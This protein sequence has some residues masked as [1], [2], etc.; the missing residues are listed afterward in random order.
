M[1]SA[2][3]AE[4]DKDGQSDAEAGDGGQAVEAKFRPKPETDLG[5]PA[6]KE[7]E[8]R[9]EKKPEKKDDKEQVGKKD[10]AE[11]EVKE[12][13]GD[14]DDDSK[15]PMP[16]WKKLLYW[17]IGL[18]VL[19]AAIVWGVL[20][21]LHARHY[22]STDDA[23]VDGYI[24]QVAAQVAGRVLRIAV[25]DNQ[26]VAAGE[27]L[28]ELDPRDFQVKLEQARA[29]RATAIAQREEARAQ[30]V[31]QQAAIDQQQAQVRV[32]E[33]ELNQ[34]QTDL[35]RYRSVDPRAIARQQLDTS[36]A[37]AKA[38]AARLDAARQAVA[39]S[40]AQLEAARA[41]IEAGD[42][43]VQQ[44]EA[45]IR[46]AEL[47]LSYAS[48][49]A[50]FAGRVTKRTVQPGNYVSPGQALMAVVPDIMWVTANFKETQLTDMRGGQP[51]TISVD[52]FPDVPLK[53][54]V[55]SIQR[56]TGAVFSSL[57]AENAT[58]NYVKVV[59]R[60]PVKILFDGQAARDLPLSP[61]MSVVP[62]VT[63]R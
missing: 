28:L 1:D 33:A 56:G 22:E 38:S 58:G 27:L 21:W 40:R 36:S 46:N 25:T 52:A 2:R 39:G 47:Q 15:K 5:Q 48:I 29:Q 7:N 60:V 4:R 32:A 23:F 12:S 17:G 30:A 20:Y 3:P 53:G 24:S 44:A 42:A 45:D 59:Q 11:G 13:G 62:R 6:G 14:D 43:T 55:D 51:V 34:A 61:G 26:Q 19:V 35:A 63:V 16:R 41:K 37:T 50:P 49:G 54:H 8:R 10:A 9:P 18:L 31:V 57:P